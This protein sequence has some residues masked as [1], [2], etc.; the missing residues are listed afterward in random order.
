MAN[1]TT[2]FSLQRV[3]EPFTPTQRLK[4]HFKK[5]VNEHAAIRF[6]DVQFADTT[7]VWRIEAPED[8]ECGYA[9]WSP[10]QNA[11]TERDITIAVFDQFAWSGAGSQALTIL[12]KEA[13]Q[14]GISAL[15]AQ[16]NNNEPCTGLRVRR[17]LLKRGFEL[18]EDSIKQHADSYGWRRYPLGEY[19]ERCSFPM[20]FYKKLS[21]HPTVQAECA[22]DANQP[23]A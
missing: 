12:E 5:Y 21:P 10:R 2:K 22:T 9:W 7:D 11:P 20:F 19:V 23:E 17:W 16:V 14:A 6:L 1:L 18:S 15:H 4:E 8:K 3:T 13:R